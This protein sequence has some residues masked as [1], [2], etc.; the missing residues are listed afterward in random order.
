MATIQ[1]LYFKNVALALRLKIF[2]GANEIEY[3]KTDS[4]LED[5]SCLH[6]SR[7]RIH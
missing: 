6:K 4:N 7:V 2:I 3:Y 5:V 1:L